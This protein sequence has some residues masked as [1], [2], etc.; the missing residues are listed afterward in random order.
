MNNKYQLRRGTE[1]TPAIIQ[2]IIDW[3]DKRATALKKKLDYYQGLNDI[4]ETR[5]TQAGKATVLVNH[6]SFIT[7]INVAYLLGNPVQYQPTKGLEDTIAPVLDAYKAETID[8]LDTDLAKDISIYGIGYEYIYNDEDAQPQ[9]VVS[10]PCN[11]VLVVDTTVQ[12]KPLYGVIYR[13]VYENG[14]TT[15]TYYELTIVDDTMVHEYTM[16]SKGDTLDLVYEAPHAFGGVPLIEYI[17]NKHRIGDFENVINLIDAYNI[18]QSDRI[19][20]RK[21]LVD[22]ILVAYGLD[23]DEE[24]VKDLKENR[25]VSGVPED[26][27]LEYLIKTVN[28]TDT[29]VLRRS[30]ENDIHKISYT[31]NMSDSEFA[32]NLSGVAISYKLFNFEHHAKDKEAYFEKGLINRFTLYFNY[33]RTKSKISAPDNMNIAT[34]IDAIF[35]RSLPKNDL[36]TSQMIGNLKTAGLVS[37]QTLVGQLSFIKNPAEEVEDARADKAED[38]KYNDFGTVPEIGEEKGEPSNEE[39]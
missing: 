18:L 38:L 5:P 33:L 35:N 23:L 6:A 26:G 12:H 16:K 13:A 27:K 2:D 9:S 3:G 20:D 4:T 11:T 14:D 39:V 34:E 17:N 36:E 30:I 29:E 21:T 7:D 10:D 8:T 25:M 37:D 24:Q 28:E 19:N 22:A 32:G 31:P 1:L 15:P